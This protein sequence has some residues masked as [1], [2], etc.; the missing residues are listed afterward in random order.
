M[1]TVTN[2]SPNIK[3]L[4]LIL[5]LLIIFYLT[6]ASVFAEGLSN[7]TAISNSS[8]SETNENNNGLENYNPTANHSAGVGGVGS[9]NLATGKLTLEIPTLTTTDSLFAFTPTL[10]YNSSLAG[11]AVTS[12]NADVAFDTSY[13]PDGFKL[14]IQETII[15]KS[16]YN[17]NNVSHTY[18][19]LYDSDGTTHCFY[20]NDENTEYYDD[21]GLRLKLTFF[22]GD[23]KIA[24]TSQT[25]RTYS[26]INGSSW[27]LTS[28][29][30][31][32]G[33][34]LI[35]EFNASYQPTKVIVKPNGLSNIEILSFLYE[36]DKLIA[37]YNDA[38]KASVIFNCSNGNL[39]QVSYC[40]GN[41]NT[42]EQN[43]R[44][45]YNDLDSAENIVVFASAMYITNNSGE[46][47]GVRDLTTTE[48]V[49][50][51]TSNGKIT[52]VIEY[53]N[54]TLGQQ[55]S[56]TYGNGYT[57]V[58]STGN[59]ETLDTD[60]DIITRY[61][62]DEK[63]RAVSVY[64]MSADSGEIYG[65]TTSTY[66]EDNIIKNNLKESTAL[67]GVDPD[68]VIESSSGSEYFATIDTDGTTG[69]YKQTVFLEENVASLTESNANM[70]YIISGFGY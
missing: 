68:D 30:D 55:V 16:Y 54:N 24:N 39:S 5:S 42:T 59:D 18:Y 57:D 10:V 44:G 37:V 3:I 15:E 26:A 1:K 20:P 21:S 8:V 58:R 48:I 46:I 63:N 12:E 23:I 43:V 62:L 70:E 19:S 34:Q 61:I 31:K 17:E 67:Q 27:H 65:I 32:Y 52:K 2:Y 60:D 41:E 36:N 56:Y 50:Y 14:N 51:Q 49:Y 13:M 45:A 22:G 28:I 6:P 35:F 64:S 4:S 47:T 53:A 7:D 38:S 66:E 40:Y 9:I 69:V 25:V 33:N 11:K 29:T